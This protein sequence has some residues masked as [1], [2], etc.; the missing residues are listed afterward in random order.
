MKIERIPGANAVLGAPVGWD[1]TKE[2]VCEPL[3]VVRHE[4][5]FVSQWRP[6]Q[7]ELE[8]MLNGAPIWLHVF[9]AGHPPVSIVVAP[10]PVTEEVSHAK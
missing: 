1:A 4:S 10:M 6:T 3:H 8:A 9:G 5:G 7:E 2:G